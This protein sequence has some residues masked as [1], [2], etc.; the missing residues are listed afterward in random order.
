MDMY[1]ELE[2]LVN[3]DMSDNG[4]SHNIVEDIEAYWEVM[5]SDD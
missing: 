2:T 5:L 1:S 4:Y 3:Q